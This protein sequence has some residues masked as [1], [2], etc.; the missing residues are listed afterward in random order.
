MLKTCDKLGRFEKLGTTSSSD[1]LTINVHNISDPHSQKLQPANKRKTDEKKVDVGYN[2][3]NKSSDEDYCSKETNSY[4]SME[5]VAKLDEKQ[6]QVA[7]SLRSRNIENS[8]RKKKH[9]TK[10]EKGNLR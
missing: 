10:K 2:F 6:S 1:G 9:A 7:Y 8:I 4:S 3:S 5:K